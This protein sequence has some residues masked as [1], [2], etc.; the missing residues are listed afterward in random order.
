MAIGVNFGRVAR[1]KRKDFGRSAAGVKNLSSTAAKHYQKKLGFVFSL[2]KVFFERSH[3]YFAQSFFSG[4]CY[5]WLSER[6]K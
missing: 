1:H 4:G 6:A 3:F 2:A 5:P